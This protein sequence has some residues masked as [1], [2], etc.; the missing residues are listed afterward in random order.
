MWI[1]AQGEERWKRGGRRKKEEEVRWAKW[2]MRRKQN[3]ERCSS[4]GSLAGPSPDC[5]G[6][7][8]EKKAGCG[9]GASHWRFG[10][11]R[12]SSN[13]RK[14]TEEIGSAP[15]LPRDI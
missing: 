5:P 3:D 13:I 14:E 6:S 9:W 10:V 12:R 1:V 11:L 8:Q 4:G 15:H 2:T 7:F